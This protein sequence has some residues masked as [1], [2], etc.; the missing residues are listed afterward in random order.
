MR[1]AAA[2]ETARCMLAPMCRLQERELWRHT[3]KHCVIRMPHPHCI[4]TITGNAAIH[5]S[6]NHSRDARFC[7]SRATNASM[8]AILSP[9]SISQT[10]DGRRKILRLYRLTP[11]RL[12][13]YIRHTILVHQLSRDAKSCVSQAK[14]IADTST[15]T[16]FLL[17]Y[18]SSGDARFCVSTFGGWRL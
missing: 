4:M 13:D 9:Q 17:T 14:D 7:V 10:L 12:H 5:M 6:A 11:S 3:E 15:F 16:P 18:S 1:V 8:T 2:H